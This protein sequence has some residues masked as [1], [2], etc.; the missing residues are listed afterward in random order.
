MSAARTDNQEAPTCRVSLSFVD[1]G[2]ELPTG[3]TAPAAF[4]APRIQRTLDVLVLVA[5]KWCSGW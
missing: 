1:R 4:A 2:D 5:D 3:V